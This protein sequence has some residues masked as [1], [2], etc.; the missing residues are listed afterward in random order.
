MAYSL[1]KPPI[2]GPST[3]L[4]PKAVQIWLK[5]ADFLYGLEMSGMKPYAADI[6]AAVIPLMTRAANSTR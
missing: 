4:I 2:T 6:A 5:L 1:S 3:K